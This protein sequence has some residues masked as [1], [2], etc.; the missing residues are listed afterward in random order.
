MNKFYELFKSTI[1]LHKRFD[2]KQDLNVSFDIFFEEYAEC[3]EAV[4]NNDTDN[5]AEEIVDAIVTSIKVWQNI[6]AESETTKQAF[7]AYFALVR[8]LHEISGLAR[9]AELNLSDLEPYFDKVIAKNNAKTEETHYLNLE[10]GKI[11]RRR[12]KEEIL[13]IELNSEP[14]H[15]NED[16][17]K[18]S[19]AELNKLTNSQLSNDL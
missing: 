6:F 12:T 16:I 10:T 5:L 4:A 19:L 1:D 11:T 2:T 14:N 3:V 8:S 9:K 17:V 15:K 18:L 7:T 13:K